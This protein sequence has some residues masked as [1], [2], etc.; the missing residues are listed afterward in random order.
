MVRIKGTYALHQLR[1]E[2]GN[3]KFLKLM[4]TIHDQYAKHPITNAQILSM[5]SE[6]GDADAA[7]MVQRWI[8]TEGLPD[9]HPAI[10]VVPGAND[11]WS[12]HLT[13]PSPKGWPTLYTHVVV[14]T[15]SARHVRPITIDAASP[16]TTLTFDERPTKIELNALNDI[17][18]ANDNFYVWGNLTDDFHHTLIVYGTARED[19]ANHTLARRWQ[20]TVANAYI[21]ILPPLVKDSEL[22]TED[23]ATHDLIVT[24]TLNDN[25]LFRD[26]L[27]GLPVTFGRNH[28]TWQG[29]TYADPDDGLFL[30][31]PNPYNHDRVMYVL[32]ANSALELWEMTKRYERNIPS[33]AIYHGDKIVARGYHAP[34]GFIIDHPSDAP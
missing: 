21:E 23:A 30:V 7:G 8:S 24:G 20:E 10:R 31:V 9:L 5:I 6:Y 28:F 1:L 33:W 29:R 13:V 17:P 15:D 18:V 3:Q 11:T 22:T 16:D 2:L 34:A 4:R 27:G 25:A 19:E 26:G 12:V 32:A 14:E